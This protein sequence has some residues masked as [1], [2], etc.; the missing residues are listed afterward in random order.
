MYD[1]TLE[2]INKIKIDITDEDDGSRKIKIH[3]GIDSRDLATLCDKIT[4]H[5]PYEKDGFH[6]WYEVLS[7]ED[8]FKIYFFIVKCAD[9][10]NV[11]ELIR[12]V[13]QLTLG[14]I[15]NVLELPTR[16]QQEVEKSNY[17]EVIDSKFEFYVPIDDLKAASEKTIEVADLVLSST[18]TGGWLKTLNLN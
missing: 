14:G 5:S 1:D 12:M 2:L 16:T 9:S 13:A 6:F 3:A 8:I 4:K 7:A 11:S 10:N 15:L 17:F 18:E